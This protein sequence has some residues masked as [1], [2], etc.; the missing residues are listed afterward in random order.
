MG[1]RYAESLGEQHELL[2][3]ADFVP[4]LPEPVQYSP[5]GYD[6]LADIFKDM[7]YADRSADRWCHSCGGYA[8]R[9]LSPAQCA[10]YQGQWATYQASR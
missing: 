4:L 10:Y 2:T 3:L 7:M 8:V 1:C 5:G 9:R 6:S